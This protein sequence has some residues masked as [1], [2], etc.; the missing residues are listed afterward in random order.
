MSRPRS[1]SSST[2][3]KRPSRSMTAAT[4]TL[5]FQIITDGIAPSF[6]ISACLDS[7]AAVPVTRYKQKGQGTVPALYMKAVGL[8]RHFFL[9]LGLAFFHLFFL[10]RFALFLGLA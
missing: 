9:F 7:N 5:G 4:V 3:R 8:L 2:S 10:L 6:E 1:V